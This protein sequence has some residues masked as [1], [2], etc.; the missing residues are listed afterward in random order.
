MQTYFFKGILIAGCFFSIVSYGQPQIHYDQKIAPALLQQDFLLLR[1]TLQKS[2]PGLYRYQ[3]K[4]RMDYVFD[5]CYASIRDSETDLQFF[6]RVAY[7]VASV[8]DGHTNCNPPKETLN[9]FRDHEKFFPALVVFI[10]SRA[11]MYCSNQD[12]LLRG[13][14]L[15]SINGRPMD[16]IVQRIYQYVQS[17]GF[18]SSHKDTELP[19]GFNLLYYMIF[20]PADR[21]AITC[22]TLAGKI[23]KATLEAEQFKNIFCPTPYPRPTKWLELCYEKGNVAVLTI[24][25]FFDGFLA[26]SGEHFAGFLD[27]AFTDI[28]KKNVSRLLID[29][30]RNQGGNDRSEEHTSEL[31]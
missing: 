19:E 5:S 18:I 15:L 11:Y 4:T 25:T 3:G 17:D 21:F 22:R 10:H 30:R 16:A 13:A 23:Q 7:I 9:E 28:R 8:G 6:T 27:S 2:Q 26:Q 12:T 31:Q 14:E 24:K 1:D 20:G 29:L